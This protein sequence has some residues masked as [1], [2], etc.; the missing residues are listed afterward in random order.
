MFNVENKKIIH[1]EIKAIRN[2]HPEVTPGKYS[3]VIF[4]F[5]FITFF[6]IVIIM[7][8]LFYKLLNILWIYHNAIR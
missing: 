3:P 1:R 8:M 6:K 4:L 2:P 7:Y 5:M